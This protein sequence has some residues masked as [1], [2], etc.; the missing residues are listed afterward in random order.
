[1]RRSML[2]QPVNGKCYQSSSLPSKRVNCTKFIDTFEYPMSRKTT[3][4]IYSR[5]RNYF[6][7]L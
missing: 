1:M 3:C 6:S 5:L 2:R 4:R 7:R